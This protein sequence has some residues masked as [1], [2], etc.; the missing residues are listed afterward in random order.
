METRLALVVPCYQEQEV[1]PTTFE[2]L[3]SL[4]NYLIEKGKI[5]EDSF[6]LYVDDGSRDRTWSLIDERA[7]WD[8]TVYG[9]KLSRNVGHQNALLAG[10]TTAMAH[11]DVMVTIDADLQDDET[12]VETMLD[13]YGEGCDIVYG[14]RSD[15]SSDSFFKRTT[16]QG[17]YR[18][19]KR[20]GV[21]T[22]YNHAD[23]RLMSRRAVEKLLT[24]E[25]RNIFLRGVVPL[26]GSRTATVSYAR[27]ERTA[28]KS[29]YPLGK[30]LSFAFEGITSF[31]IKPIGLVLLIGA[32]IVLMSIA[33]TVYSLI[34]HFAGHTVPGWTSLMI[35]IWFLGGVQLLSIGLIGE[36]IGKVYLETKHRPRYH[37][38]C[39]HLEKQPAPKADR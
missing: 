35:S 10:L 25:E 9:V 19:M 13:R 7:A 20:L 37:I 39:S 1:L 16:A 33:A 17:F 14:V 26:I 2:R 12:V 15:R 4:L 38:E 27:K 5:R 6:V 29:K 30:M 32:L 8:K 22:V 23:F 11:A 31:S 21:P 34:S 24:Y 18:L 28:G 3:T 36:Y